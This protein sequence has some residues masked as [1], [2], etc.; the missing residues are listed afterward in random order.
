MSLTPNFEVISLADV[1]FDGLVEGATPRPLVLVVDDE[2]AI[3][4]SLAMILSKSGFSALTAYD[5]ESALRLASVAPPD[6]LLSD[7][8]MGP[9]MD[10]VA[11]AIT[12]VRAFPDCK[13]LLFS[14]HAATRD[15]LEGARKA[16][17]NFTLLTKPLHPSDLLER[18]RG[19]LLTQEMSTAEA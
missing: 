8:M 18:I 7:V 19:T 5:A 14:G 4:D 12:L 16:G 15:L 17:Y 13:V 2:R 1:P 3:A 9:G 6:L 10:G 11:L